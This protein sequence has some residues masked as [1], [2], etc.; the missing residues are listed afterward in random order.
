MSRDYE[1]EFDLKNLTAE[2]RDY[3]ADRLR[4]LDLDEVTDIRTVTGPNGHYV[5]AR[6]KVGEFKGRVTIHE[7]DDE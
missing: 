3:V 7:I 2:Q 5:R 1:T 6:F 4:E